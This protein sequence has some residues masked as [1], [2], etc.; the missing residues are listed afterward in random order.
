[1]VIRL[2]TRHQI[3]I[4][5]DYQNPPEPQQIYVAPG[6]KFTCVGNYETS[7]DIV[8]EQPA[9]DEEANPLAVD[10]YDIVYSQNIDDDSCKLIYAVNDS[11]SVGVWLRGPFP[12]WQNY[13]SNWQPFYTAREE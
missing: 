10:A 2:A 13:D 8:F 1:M 4:D 12:M 3:E 6:A 11:S 7:T 5:I 9:I